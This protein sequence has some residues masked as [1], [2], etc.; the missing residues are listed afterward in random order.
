MMNRDNG[1]EP[2]SKSAGNGNRQ[3]VGDSNSL[4]AQSHEAAESVKNAAL[5]RLENA[6]ASAES[7]KGQA[8]ERVRGLGSAIR[9]VGEHLRVEEQE[10]L[11]GYAADASEHIESVASYI[12]RAELRTVVNDTESLARR[13]PTMFFG[14]ALLLG[15]AAGRFLKSSA[16]SSASTSSA[17]QAR[18]GRRHE[19]ESPQPHTQ[20]EVATPVVSGSVPV[21]RKRRVPQ[22]GGGDI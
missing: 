15:L 20:R 6:F 12:E 11:A 18:P 4:A 22:D 17:G 2:R 10:M 13:R 8:A 19:R 16:G 21:E 1:T 7:M 5:E 14:G 3:T 9:K